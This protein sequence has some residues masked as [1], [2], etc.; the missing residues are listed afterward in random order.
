PLR[1]VKK[2]HFHDYNNSW[3]LDVECVGNDV[4]SVT[5]E[6]VKFLREGFGCTELDEQLSHLQATCEENRPMYFYF[7]I[8]QVIETNL[9]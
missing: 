3:F 7:V 4:V 5:D 1:V 8:G 6:D 2:I 9:H